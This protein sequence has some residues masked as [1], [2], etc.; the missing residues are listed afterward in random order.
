MLQVRINKEKYKQYSNVFFTSDPHYYH[1]KIIE[2]CD[3]PFNDVGHMNMSLINNWN[4]VVNHSDIVFITGDF[5][6]FDKGVIKINY[7]LEQLNGTK[8]LI[9]GNHDDFVN[10][11][12]PW[13]T[14]G[15][16]KFL[17]I[18]E[19]CLIT[20]KG[21]PEISEQK[22]FMNH[23]PMLT[24]NA[25]HKGSWQVY[26]HIHSL[27][28]HKYIGSPTQY[29]VG[30]DRNNFTPVSWNQLKTNITKQGLNVQ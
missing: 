10:L 29:D 2:Y 11:E 14:I 27:P 13:L 26:G 30:V 25:S 20:I 15:E 6:P 23:Y 4:K 24:W 7:I 17:N 12:Q 18:F 22:I 19:Q 5:V 9:R 1:E 28:H 8:V 21:D 16:T 3:R